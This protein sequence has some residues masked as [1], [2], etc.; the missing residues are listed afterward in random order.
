MKESHFKQKKFPIVK[1]LQIIW[2]IIFKRQKQFK[3]NKTKICNQLRN[4]QH[5]FILFNQIDQKEL[6]IQGHLQKWR[7]YSQIHM[8]IAQ[9]NLSY[10]ESSQVLRVQV[11]I[12]LKLPK[13]LNSTTK[14]LY[15]II[16][17]KN[18][19]A[20]K[21][22]LQILINKIKKYKFKKILLFQNF[23][24]KLSFHNQQIKHQIFQ[25]IFMSINYVQQQL[26]YF[27]F[28]KNYLILYCICQSNC[29]YQILKENI[30]KIKHPTN[31]IIYF[32]INQ[33]CLIINVIKYFCKNNI[34]FFFN[35]FFTNQILKHKCFQINQMILLF[36]TQFNKI[37]NVLKQ[38][39]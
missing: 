32:Y 14:H 25:S 36:I 20:K 37:I 11:Q 21:Q 27:F 10:K 26:L 31:F 33:L 38:I 1:R 15:L 16:K 5:V 19:T 9:L 6:L 29:I 24:N 34:V 8:E 12:L 28:G 17:T 7:Q 4:C 18:L 35:Q 13:L 22:I 3:K 39:I 23:E 30:Q 2:L